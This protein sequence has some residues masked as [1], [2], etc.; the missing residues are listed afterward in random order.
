[1]TV[2]PMYKRILSYLMD[3]RLEQTSSPYNAN[4]E[5]LL[6]KGRL[7]LATTNAIYSYDDLYDTFYEPFKQLQFE[8]KKLS[9]VLVL[10]FG[11]G[12]IPRML[13]SHFKQQ[14]TTFTGVEI[15]AVIIDLAKKYMPAQ[16]DK[17]VKIY[18][19][20]AYDFI[21]QH[22][23]VPTYDLIAVDVFLD[24][25]TPFKFRSPRFIKQLQQLL[26]ING[27]LLYNCLISDATLYE[28]YKRFHTQTFSEL[29]PNTQII[30]TKGNKML[31]Y[32]HRNIV[33]TAK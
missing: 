16:I 2:I 13:H 26:N 28:T 29:L 32:Q 11:L 33:Q 25:I 22:P 3:V 18:K 15:D 17:Q 6:S 7:M 14:N 12:A 21:Q 19:A 30:S 10:G 23:L 4:L 9:K 24:T 27:Y 31:V 20:D 5:V 8:Q 1:M